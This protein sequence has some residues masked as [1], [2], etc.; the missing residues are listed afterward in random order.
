[1]R[2]LCVYIFI[3]L[4]AQLDFSNIVLKPCLKGQKQMGKGRR[5]YKD[6]EAIEDIEIRESHLIIGPI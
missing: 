2:I 1:M 5:Y 3:I 6:E 4:S